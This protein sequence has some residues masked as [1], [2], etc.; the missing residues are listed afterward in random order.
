VLRHFEEA[1]LLEVV[2]N[3]LNRTLSDTHLGSDIPQTGILIF[4][5]ANQHVA[6]VAEKS[7]I[8]HYAPSQ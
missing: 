4:C 2:D 7:P 5:K 8:A 6:V 1:R 3:F